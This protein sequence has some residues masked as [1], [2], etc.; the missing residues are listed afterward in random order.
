VVKSISILVIGNFIRSLVLVLTAGLSVTFGQEAGESKPDVSKP[1]VSKP[2]VAM[3][4]VAKPLTVDELAAGEQKIREVLDRLRDCLKRAKIAE[5]SYISGKFD[6]SENWDAAY[7]QAIKDGKSIRQEL[8]DLAYPIILQSPKLSSEMQELSVIVMLVL[9]EEHQYERAYQVASRLDQVNST[10]DTKYYRMRTA[11][12]TNRFA[13]ALELREQVASRV[14]DLPELELD[15]LKSLPQLANIGAEEE[16]LRQVDEQSNLPRVEMLTSEGPIII[17]LFEDQYPETVGHFIFL[18]ESGFYKDLVFHR[19]TKNFLP[20][21]VA[22]SGLLSLRDMDA[23]QQGWFVHDIKY[24]IMDEVPRGG[25]VRRHLRGVISL[26]IKEDP[27]KEERI[28]HS[29][30]SPFMITLVP[31]PALDGNQIAFGRVIEGLEVIDRI[32]ATS[33]ISAEDGKESPI[34]HPN[35]SKLIE[36]RVLRKRDHEYLPNKVK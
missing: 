22:Q 27:K 2:D 19:V 13:E 30:G 10:D 25:V 11:M 14:K 3:P 6:E 8:L 29:G 21:S 20:F 31:T 17:E 5:F 23:E 4:D 1:D 7:Q 16:Q 9:F 32:N 26:S 36:T 35:F 18:V 33:T 28:P 12:V 34:E 24:S 15:M